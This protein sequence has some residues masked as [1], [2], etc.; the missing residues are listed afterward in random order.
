MSCNNENDSERNS[1]KCED[2]GSQKSRHDSDIQDYFDENI[3]DMLPF[4]EQPKDL[5]RSRL[6]SNFDHYLEWM[7]VNSLQQYF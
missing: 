7:M 3:E 6:D 4:M 5:Y 1:N 2:E